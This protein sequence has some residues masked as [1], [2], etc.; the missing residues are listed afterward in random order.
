MTLPRALLIG[1][2]IGL[3]IALGSGGGIAWHHWTQSPAY[4]LKAIAGAVEHRDRYQFERYVDIDSVVQSAMSDV[5]E[6][7]ALATAV[8]GAIVPQLKAEIIKAIED[9][10]VRPD[11]QFGAGLQRV[12]QGPLPDVERQGRNAY[13]SVPVTTKGGAPFALKFHMTQ[14]PDGYW[15]VDRLANMKELR[16]TEEREENA[17]KAAIAKANEEK[18]AKLTAV[19]K[20]HTSVV[21]GWEKKN[22]FQVRFE[23]R[24]DKAVASFSARLRVSSADFDE[25][26]QARMTKIEPGAAA[27][28]V[29]ELDANRFIQPTWRVYELGETEQF[30]VD[31]NLITFADG[32]TVRRGSEE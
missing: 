14:V 13:F 17:R 8:G 25:G 1:G 23:N 19:A 15:R 20:L 32:T 21:D 7:N 6:G 27:T 4:S 10:K 9:G 24:S 26:I 31:V 30:D 12:L 28:L 29:W 11:S 5:A 16:S 22:R 3:V 18:L 2:P